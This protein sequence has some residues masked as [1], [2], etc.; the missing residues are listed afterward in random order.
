MVPRIQMAVSWQVPN[1]LALH[2]GFVF[3]VFF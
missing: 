3:W 1:G 2:F